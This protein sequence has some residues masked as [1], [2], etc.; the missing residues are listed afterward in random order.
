MSGALGAARA[1]VAPALAPVANDW[2]R[3]NARD[4][5]WRGPH[6][7]PWGTLLIEFMAQQTQIERAGAVWTRWLERWP[8]P[9][10]LAAASPDEVLRAWGRL[11]YPRRALALHRT[12]TEI[13]ERHGGV[14]PADVATLL[15]LPGI[16][17]YT[18]AAVA[19]FAYGVRTPVVDTNI[20]RVLARAVLGQGEPGAPSARRDLALMESV[21]PEDPEE[22]RVTNIAVMEIGALVCTARAPRCDACPLAADCAWRAAGYPAYDGPRRARQARFHGSDRQLRGRIMAQLR[23]AHRPVPEAEL[24][25]L[26]EDAEQFRRAL[27]GLV[28]DGLATRTPAGYALPTG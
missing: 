21:L 16:G 25:E 4:F 22:A 27:A 18:A 15:G 6:V 5:P 13:A 20:R 7:T 10:A 1:Q 24:A 28:R 23:A 12:A 14:V 17:P 11:G 9:A 3:A 8:T 2:Y 26:A 19:A